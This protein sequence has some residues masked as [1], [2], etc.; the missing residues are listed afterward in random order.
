MSFW[1]FLTGGTVNAVK[2]IASE[3]IETNQEKAE[4][5]AVMVK[6]LD[7]NGEM[8]RKLST[9]ASKAYGFYLINAVILL[10]MQAFGIG[11]AEGAKVATEMIKELFLPITTAWG[12]IVTASFG[13]NGVNS[14]KGN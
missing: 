3:W 2:D 12:G 6:A 7:P 1:N 11:D 5:Q 8:R 14:Y 4:A 13:V 9:F 10:Y